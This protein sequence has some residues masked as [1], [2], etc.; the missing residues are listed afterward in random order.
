M[1]TNLRIFS[2]SGISDISYALGNI[3]I[4]IK[5]YFVEEDQYLKFIREKLSSDYNL[6]IEIINEGRKKSVLISKDKLRDQATRVVFHIVK[7]L[8][9][10]TK[11][12]DRSNAML[13]NG[14]LEKYSLDIINYTYSNQTV[15]LDALI[16]DLDKEEIKNAIN[17]SF[18]FLNEYIDNL[19]HVVSEWKNELQVWFN[20]EAESNNNVS[21]YELHIQLRN[22]INR[23]L[24]IY[25]EA[26]SISNP[27]KYSDLERKIR[28]I[29]D[30]TN[31]RIK[32]NMQK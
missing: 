1:K 20:K 31:N 13:V 19:K 30:Y 26:M 27:D 11:P 7:G 9:Y 24:L 17:E 2:R 8:T 22:T 4:A 29:I 32:K 25:I 5:D 18:S 15:A 6:L 28:S 23:E 14:V 16:K 10:L 3:L 21:A 12:K